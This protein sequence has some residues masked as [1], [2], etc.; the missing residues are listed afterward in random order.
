[1]GKTGGAV[2]IGGTDATSTRSSF[3]P[4]GPSGFDTLSTL[5]PPC[6]ETFSLCCHLGDLPRG[7]TPHTP[8]PAQ[9]TADLSSSCISQHVESQLVARPFQRSL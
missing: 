6:R 2:G 1:M 8:H 5:L 4:Q 3:P 9:V 7:L